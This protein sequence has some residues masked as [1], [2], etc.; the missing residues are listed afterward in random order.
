MDI[1]D[2]SSPS[3]KVIQD[4]IKR[5]QLSTKSHKFVEINSGRILDG[6]LTGFTIYIGASPQILR[7]YDKNKKE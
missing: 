2:D 1:F 5:G 4:Y 6:K 7:I 3:V